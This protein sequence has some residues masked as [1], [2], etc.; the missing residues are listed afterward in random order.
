MEK[1]PTKWTLRF[2]SLFYINPL[3]HVSALL[4]HPQGDSLVVHYITEVDGCLIVAGF[5]VVHTASN[6]ETQTKIYIET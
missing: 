2:S 3:Q 1:L 5:L 4:G 6:M